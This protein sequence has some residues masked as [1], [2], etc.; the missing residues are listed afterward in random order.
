MNKFCYADLL[1]K[2]VIVVG[3]SYT[4]P[5]LLI[6]LEYVCLR[7]VYYDAIVKGNR[8]IEVFEYVFGIEEFRINGLWSKEFA[9]NNEYLCRD[10]SGGLLVIGHQA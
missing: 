2:S 7:I 10:I 1:E 8:S 6:R 5:P 4:M 3:I 9:A